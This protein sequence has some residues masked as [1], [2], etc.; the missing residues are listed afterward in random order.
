MRK[1]IEWTINLLV[2]VILLIV[3]VALF[4]AGIN[5]TGTPPQ[6]DFQS[7]TVGQ[8]SNDQ[9]CTDNKNG[10]ICIQ[11]GDFQSDLKTFCGCLTNQNC[12]SGVCGEDNKCS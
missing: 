9:D 12:K 4:W 10:T 1:G 2:A 8:C 6:S 11:I 3:I 5:S 7:S